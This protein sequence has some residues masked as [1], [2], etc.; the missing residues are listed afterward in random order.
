MHVRRRSPPRSA[1]TTWR[2]ACL[3]RGPPFAGTGMPMVRALLRGEAGERGRTCAALEITPP[4]APRH[5]LQFIRVRQRE[6]AAPDIAWAC[7]RQAPVASIASSRRSAKVAVSADPG[8]QTWKER[9]PHAGL[10]GQLFQ[11][12]SGIF[13]PGCSTLISGVCSSRIAWCFDVVR[14]ECEHRPC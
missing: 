13:V 6:R 14:P 2:I 4:I 12:G 9:H 11:E 5:S 7:R 10:A 3:P 8:S 1:R